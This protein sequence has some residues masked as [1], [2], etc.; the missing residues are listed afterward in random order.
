MVTGRVPFEGEDEQPVLL[1][2]ITQD[3][4]PVTALRVGVPTELDRILAKAMAKNPTERYQHIEDM[5]VDPGVVPMFELQR[6]NR[7]E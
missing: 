3:H 1:S 6:H 4:E 2:V 5:L 7:T